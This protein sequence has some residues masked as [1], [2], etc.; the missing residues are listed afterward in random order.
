MLEVEG[1]IWDYHNK[2]YWIAI[3]TNGDVK[4]S[5]AA[6]MGR[7][8]ALQAVQRIP[9]A[10]FELGRLLKKFGPHV[11]PIGFKIV[12]FPVKYHWREKASLDLILKSCVEA[13]YHLDCADL[14]K[15]TPP[16]YMV[17]PGCG[18]GELNWPDVKPILEKYLDDR[19]IVVS[20]V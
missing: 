5:G 9:N 20:N 11:Y 12:A 2:G 3:T 18:N 14:N 17:R 15:V 10:Q 8:V 1:D 19:F 16:V 6:V 7:G 4:K 13:V